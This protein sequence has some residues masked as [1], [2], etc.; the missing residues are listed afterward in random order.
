M[1]EQPRHFGQYSLG[2]R[3]TK[4]QFDLATELGLDQLRAEYP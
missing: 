3:R 2:I 1:K 4:M